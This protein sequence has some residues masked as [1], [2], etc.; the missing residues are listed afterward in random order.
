MEA[1]VNTN[2]EPKAV[3]EYQYYVKEFIPDEFGLHNTGAICWFNSLLQMMLGLPSV[4]RTLLE[5]EQ[6]LTKNVFAQ[7]YIKLLKASLTNQQID[8]STLAAASHS[9]LRGFISQLKQKNMSFNIGYNQECADEAFTLFIDLL[10]CP[11]V[12][13]LF[14]N[15]Y[16]LII[17]CKHC[18]QDVSSIRDKSYRIQLFTRVKLESQEKFC[19]YL[20]IHPSE[21][22]Y[23]KCEKCGETMTKF[24]RAER[25]RVLREVVV[26]VFDKFHTKDN[27]WFPQELQFN[28]AGGKS[29]LKYKIVGKIEHSG[30]MNGGHYWAHS[31]RG[32]NWQC[33][34]DTSVRPG[35][36]NPTPSTFMVAYHLVSPDE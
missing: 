4:N 9:I 30:T 19:T 26:I 36:S 2:N 31:L 17:K 11:Q 12:E 14:S 3:A 21:C 5:C 6:S 33:L 25:L 7:E 35:S 28:A 20:K 13:K 29:P 8:K 16:E 23:Y 1:I 24:N 10:D 32:D 18:Q 27:R 22:D 15:V 34:N